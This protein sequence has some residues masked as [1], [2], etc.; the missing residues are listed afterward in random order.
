MEDVDKKKRCGIDFCVSAF[1]K[2]LSKAR[3]TRASEGTCTC[4]PSIKKE[5]LSK[6]ED[7][8]NIIGGG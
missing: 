7:G 4:F 8:G 6:K 3:V 2:K 5:H 1:Y